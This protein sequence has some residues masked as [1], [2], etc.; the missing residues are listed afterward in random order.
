MISED[1]L[2][3]ISH[4]FC[5]DIEGYYSYKSGPKLVNF[6]N[7]H[8]QR[9][10]KYGQGFPSRWAYV[11]DRLADLI[12]AGSFDTFLNLILSKEYLMRDMGL[13]QV[14]AA[15][16]SQEIFEEFN[17]LVQQDLYII[18]NV[19]GNYHLGTQN[20]DLV[21]I[22]SG[23]FANVFRQK[24]TGLIIKKLK[25]DFL[26]DPGIRSRF[27]REFDITNSLRDAYGIIQVYSF[28]ASSCSYTM[29]P[30]EQTLEDYLSSA[31][32][33][34]NIRINC[35]RQILF[36]M[37]EVHKRDI[38]HRDL[39]P[40][41]IFVIEGMLKI[42]DFGLGKDLNVFASHRT[43]FTNA[44]GQYYYCAPE[45]F[46]LLRDGDKRSDVYSLG[47]TINYVMTDDPRNSHH[48]FR[49]V[50]EKATNSDAAYRCADAGQLLTLFEK[51]VAFHQKTENETATLEKVAHGQFD[52]DVETYIYELT[53]DKLSKYL[54]D[55]KK[56]IIN[57]LIMFMKCD[58]THA[59][60]IIQS[61]ES[62]FRD[63]C[64]REFAAYDSFA[65]F[66]Y[67][68]LGEDFSY[69]VKETAAT[70]LRYV[71]TDVNR[72]SA[73]HLVDELKQKGIEPMLEDILDS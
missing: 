9:E 7:E 65:T 68:V 46:M 67:R 8:F 52:S 66:A 25:D 2:Q 55:G 47:R 38:I 4:M 69:V 31:S 40:N 56:G 58:D 41:N 42:A 29:E 34:E 15:E 32:I 3:T 1:V 73:Q 23:G 53:A 54:L 59:Q 6:F 61:V 12:N 24:S 51:S 44:V 16:K 30:A 57:A 20:E 37:S 72:F 13:T 26:T 14:Q 50:A 10:D 36:I 28:D 48:I 18:T 35:I 11:F 39:S 19:R 63:I 62:T 33:T 71:A 70:I 43:L 5:G 60:H 22:G 45:Q 49:S 17:R 64:G 27:K 21:L